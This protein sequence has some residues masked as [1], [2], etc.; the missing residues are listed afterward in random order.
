MSESIRRKI[1]CAKANTLTVETKD[2]IA[3]WA[4][5][6]QSTDTTLQARGGAS[7]TRNGVGQYSVS[8]PTHPDGAAYEILFGV[9][10]DANRD[11]PK[12]SVVDGTQTPAGFDVV[13]T[14]DDNGT[15]ADVF[16]DEPWS[17]AVLYECPVVTSVTGQGDTVQ[18][19][20]LQSIGRA[21]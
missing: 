17:F 6:K 3:V 19:T 10:E 7:I 11:I 1:G 16:N 21:P 15:V 20:E 8:F 18:Q 2:I 12:V 14:V 5:G 9:D 4:S 13:V